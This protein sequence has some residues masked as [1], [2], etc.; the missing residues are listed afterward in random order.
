MNKEEIMNTFNERPE[1]KE[2]IKLY[3][4]LSEE[5]KEK[6][7]PSLLRILKDGAEATL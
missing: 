2:L 7:L 3:D 1:I 5:R 4:A 6:V